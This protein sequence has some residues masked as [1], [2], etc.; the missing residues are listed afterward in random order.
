MGQPIA[1][2]SV[3]I[4]P[5]MQPLDDGLERIEVL[6]RDIADVIARYRATSEQAEA[7]PCGGDCKCDTKEIASGCQCAACVSGVMHASDCSVHNEPAFPNG[8]CDCKTK[9]FATA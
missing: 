3:R 9:E 1:T 2:A 8:P 4:A 6:L 7:C 5:D